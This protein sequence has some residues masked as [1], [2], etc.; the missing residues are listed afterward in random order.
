LSLCI[1]PPEG[2][3]HVQAGNLRI[4]AL[5]AEKRLGMS[6]EIPMVKEQGIRPALGMW[7]RLAADKGASPRGIKNPHDSFKQRMDNPA[8][9]KK[10]R[11][12]RESPLF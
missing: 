10:K 4:I 7:S 12:D 8:H 3:S 2:I 6:P 5:F 9:R 1:N 11:Y